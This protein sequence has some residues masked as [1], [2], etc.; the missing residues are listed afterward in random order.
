MSFQKKEVNKD[1]TSYKTKQLST[2]ATLLIAGP[3][4]RGFQHSLRVRLSPPALVFPRP[5]PVVA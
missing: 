3:H 4:T 5:F 1:N 2:S